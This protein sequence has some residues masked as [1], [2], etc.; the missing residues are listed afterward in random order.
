[1]KLQLVYKSLYVTGFT[2]RMTKRKILWDGKGS[3]F[4]KKNLFC[5]LHLDN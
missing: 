3:S 5:Y 4:L 2:T 1:V